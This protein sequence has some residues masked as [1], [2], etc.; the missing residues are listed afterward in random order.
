MP[1]TYFL[2]F[3]GPGGAVCDPYLLKGDGAPPP[4][5]TAPAVSVV[6]WS[7]V[8]ALVGGKTIL[9]YTHGFNVS[10]QGGAE[11]LELVAR[12]LNLAAPYLFIGMLWPG[13]GGVP[14]VDYPW[15]GGPA[16]DSGRRLATFCNTW[17]A[18]AQ[19]L[20]F[21]SHSLGA[22]MVLQAVAGLAA[23]RRAS[24]LCLMAGAINSDCLVTQYASAAAKSE[25]IAV[26]ASHE[27][28]VLKLAF[29]PGD[30]VAD[31]IY[32]DHTLQAALG[33]DGPPPPA[34]GVTAPWQIADREDFG[35]LDY[36]PPN[37]NN[38]WQWAV[39]FVRRNFYGQPLIWPAP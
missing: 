1:D 23:P 28:A 24:V 34:A 31:Q 13:D 33:Y 27:D 7:E 26:L 29:P 20:S 37:N 2:N 6:Q 14:F 21:A 19:S 4:P 15:E 3:R 11:S 17:C 38:K 16:M 22:R 10:Y 5:A 39:D 12:Y 8:P 9:F 32:H 36:M 18:A 25:R 30:A 35:H